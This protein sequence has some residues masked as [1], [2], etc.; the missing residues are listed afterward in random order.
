MNHRSA[1]QTAICA[2]VALLLLEG[3][4]RAAEPDAVER[5]LQR[6]QAAAT[7][8]ATAT[9]APRHAHSDFTDPLGRFMDFLAAGAF[10]DARTI[11][12]AACATWLATRQGSAF[13]GRFRVWD[14]EVDLD[15]LCAPG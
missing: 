3:S 13:S 4:L 5:L 10:V 1:W 9:G 7:A 6:S 11:Q 14:T 8:T 15:T 2:A 12:P